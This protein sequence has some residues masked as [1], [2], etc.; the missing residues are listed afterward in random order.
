MHIFGTQTYPEIKSKT[1]IFPRPILY[2]Q[3]NYLRKWKCR[4]HRWKKKKK[5]NRFVAPRSSPKWGHRRGKIEQTKRNIMSSDNLSDDS[6]RAGIYLYYNRMQSLSAIAWK[7]APCITICTY[8]TQHEKTSQAVQKHF[9]QKDHLKK[10]KVI[11]QNRLN[12]ISWN[13]VTL[14]EKTSRTVQKHFYQ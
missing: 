2:R 4:C 5:T 6:V 13:F 8:V 12:R 9:Y 7:L 1:A 14:F 3:R 11:T 10:R